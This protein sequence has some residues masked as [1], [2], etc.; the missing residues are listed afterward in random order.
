M[1]V[2]LDY[3]RRQTRYDEQILRHHNVPFRHVD[4][5]ESMDYDT[6][7]KFE[8]GDYLVFGERIPTMCFRTLD[9]CLHYLVGGTF[10]VA[11]NRPSA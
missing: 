9:Q 8:D 3:P 4:D 1:K 7:I 11:H 2:R 6:T 10:H 5:D